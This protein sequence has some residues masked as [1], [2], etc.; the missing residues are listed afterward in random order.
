LRVD[1]NG[2]RPERSEAESRGGGGFFDCISLHFI[3][4]RSPRSL[5]AF[6]NMQA[7]DY[8]AVHQR[9]FTRNLLT[10]LSWRGILA[11]CH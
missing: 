9:E 11:Q 5:V 6:T 7:G 3:P 4:L 2:E 8:P 10:L 1:D